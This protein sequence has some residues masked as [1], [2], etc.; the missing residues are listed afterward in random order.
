MSMRIDGGL[1][2]LPGADDPVKAS[3]SVHNERIVGVNMQSVSEETFDAEG[4]LIAPGII[5]LGVFATDKPAFRFGG[6]TR[7]ALLPDQSPVHDDPAT[8]R[9]AAL[10]GKPDF[11]GASACRRNPQFG[12]RTYGRNCSDERSRSKGSVNRTQMDR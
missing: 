12:R 5:D 11:L 1:V 8:V 10:K 3:I 9:F 2:L 4:M 7:A 6:I